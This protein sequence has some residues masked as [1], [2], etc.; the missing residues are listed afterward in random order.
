[1]TRT[2][3]KIPLDTKETLQ[4]NAG[5]MVDSFVPSTGVIGNILGATTGGINVS[6]THEFNDFGEDIDNCPKNTKE[7]KEIADTTTVIS[8]TML[9]MK[10][11]IANRLAI[12]DA[13]GTDTM[14]LVPRNVLEDTDFDDI[15]FVG[16]YGVNGSIA[17]HL[18]NALSTAGFAIQTTDKGKGQFAFEFTAHYSIDDPDTVPFEIYIDEGD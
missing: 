6:H 15:W 9:T 17:L 16:D 7:L 4:F 1:M 13:D 11:S 10:K 5:I 12:A 18:M 14:K 3:T 2:Y 8:G